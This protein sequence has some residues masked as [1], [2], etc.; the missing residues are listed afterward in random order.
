[1]DA[2][3]IHITMIAKSASN[4]VFQ[5]ARIG[6]EAAAKD[7]SE[8]YSKISVQIDWRTPREEDPQEQAERIRNAVEDGTDAIIVSCS[9]DS[10]LTVAI[11]AAVESGIPVM[12]FDSDAP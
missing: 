8:K 5:S 9:D 6:A 4:P 2:K 7:L 11:D 1:A 12:T 10:I 3:N